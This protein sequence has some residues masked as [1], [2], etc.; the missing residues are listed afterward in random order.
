MN[1]K[2][3]TCLFLIFISSAVSALAQVQSVT[4]DKKYH[5]FNNGAKLPAQ[6]NLMI[7]VAIRP[8]ISMVAMQI[9]DGNFESGKYLY[10]ATWRKGDK[11]ETVASLMSH[12]KLRQNSSYNFKFI[13]YRDL[14]VN[15]R[16]QIVETLTKTCYA[17]LQANINEGNKQYKLE[18]S[19]KQIYRNLNQVLV[20]SMGLYRQKTQLENQNTFSEL[21]ELQLKNTA[22]QKVGKGLDSVSNI[23]ALKQQLNNEITTIVDKYDYIVDEEFEVL[24]YATEKLSS[25]LAVNAGYGAVYNEGGINNLDYYD[26]P[27]AGLSFSL[28]NQAFS[29]K[30]WSN[31]S[32]SAGVF[33]KN[34]KPNNNTKISGPVV[35]LPLY[36][37]FGHK[38]FNY[39]KINAGA[40][41]LEEHNL[42]TDN[43][44]IEVRPF[45]GLSVEMFVWLGFNKRN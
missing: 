39:F 5:Q 14:A 11:T 24:D 17:L 6:T 43:K 40:T 30:F 19:P 29:S 35:G 16:Q 36:A 34:F 33:L 3:N 32:L 22:S 9:N 23:T 20:K 8:Q 10:E 2:R 38:V 18:N 41:V 44:K 37:A 42:I 21:I 28:G 26:A 13:Y 4:F 27:Y 45:I 7:N 15:E 31:S 25:A 1:F 12:F